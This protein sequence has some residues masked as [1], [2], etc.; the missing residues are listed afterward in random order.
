MAVQVTKSGG[1]LVE[2]SG[3][4]SK[5]QDDLRAVKDLSQVAGKQI[6]EAMGKAI[7]PGKITG[8]IRDM[9]TSLMR[10]QE[11]AK[12]MRADFAGQEKRIRE[13]GTVFG[14]YD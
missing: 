13:W 5:L 2:I 12:N 3:D 1:I 11:A 14:G 6:S 4:Y 8:S 7:D 10:A 9:T